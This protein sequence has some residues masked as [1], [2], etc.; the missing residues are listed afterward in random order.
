MYDGNSIK[1]V[2]CLEAEDG[3]EATAACATAGCLEEGGN[4][5]A[6]A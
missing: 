5:G 2:L 4:K 1:Q 6:L 3:E